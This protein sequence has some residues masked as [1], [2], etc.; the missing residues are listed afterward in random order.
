MDAAETRRLRWSGLLAVPIGASA[1]AVALRRWWLRRLDHRDPG[2][3]PGV[4][5]DD[6]V[7]LHVASN[8][9][10]NAGTTVVLVHGFAARAE[11]FEAQR[12]ALAGRV[13]VVAYDQRGHGRSGWSGHRAATIERLGRDLGE[14]VDRAT[15][16]R[17]IVVGHSLGGMAVL[18]LADQRPRW[19]GERIV[20]VALLS[21]SAAGL[22]SVL[23]RWAARPLL[24]TGLLQALLRL[25]WVIAPLA[26]RVQPVKTRLGARL[27]RRYMFGE[28]PVSPS[29]LRQMQQMWAATPRTVGAAFY[30]A[31]VCHDAREAVRVLRRVPTLVLVGTEDRTFPPRKS[32]YIADSAGPDTEHVTIPGA[33]HMLPVTHPETVN[34]ALHRLLDRVTERGA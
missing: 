1:A 21:T 15:Q 9:S 7:V 32:R 12:A 16:G 30:P 18:S 27:L 28:G 10:S 4:L 26:D 13:R 14:V 17:V 23:P 25:L 24:D 33:G 34:A 31:V 6:G 5:T 11:V 19:F 29:L 22:A 8:G 2:R 3:G 20:G